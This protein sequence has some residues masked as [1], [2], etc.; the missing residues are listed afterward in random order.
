MTSP[1]FVRGVPAYEDG[2]LSRRVMDQGQRMYI[3]SPLT[4]PVTV[5]GVITVYWPEM[6]GIP[7]GSC[8]CGCGAKTSLAKSSNT[9]T[10]RVKGEP[11]RYLQGHHGRRHVRY[12][13]LWTGYTSDCWIWVLAVIGRA[14]GSSATAA[15]P[16]GTRIAPTTSG[17]RVRFRQV[18]RSIT[19]AGCPRAS[20][21]APR[22]SH[23]CGEH[24]T[25]SQHEADCR[26]GRRD[27]RFR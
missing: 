20:I 16:A 5:D 24:T 4:A 25:R 26:T 2:R 19:F 27:T 3:P 11:R 12:L 7:L 23:S 18:S 15:A 22:S 13:K 1:L 17:L 14:T 10:G 6:D 9:S 8:G 21:R